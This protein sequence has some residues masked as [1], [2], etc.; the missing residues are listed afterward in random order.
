MPIQEFTEERISAIP[1]N[2]FIVLSAARKAG[3]SHLC[4]HIVRCLG[5][6]FSAAFVCSTT[7]KLQDSFPF[8]E[9]KNH[10]NPNE[11]GPIEEF[12]STILDF[13]SSR[14]TSGKPIG[15]VLLIFDDIFLNSSSGPG[16]FSKNLSRIAATGRH[17]HIFVFLITQR[18]AS[19]SPSIRSQATDW[20]TFR[21]RSST[22]RNMLTNQFLS[23]ESGSA[24]ESRDRA[25]EL[26]G[27]IFDGSDSAYKA[28]WIRADE[29]S[30]HLDDIVH[31][32]RAP[33]KLTKWKMKYKKIYDAN[34]NKEEK[35]TEEDDF[36]TIL[37]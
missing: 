11:D 19:L 22:E 13:Q 23:R 15:Q 28:M 14:K 21:P 12:I 35:Q 25:K 5:N 16:R 2:S 29:R 33:E 34:S 24:R 32:A 26:M 18:W 4:S 37:D 36:F 31:W 1:D 10:H 7:S 6:R 3:K 8:I 27:S 9:S 30:S 17:L 20:I